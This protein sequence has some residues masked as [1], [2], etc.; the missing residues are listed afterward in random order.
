MPFNNYLYKNL[1]ID[2][3]YNLLK[4][5]IINE[6]DNLN[7]YLSIDEGIENRIIKYINLRFYE[8]GALMS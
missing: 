5:K 1:S 3:A 2:N 4:Y 6:I 8:I 7:K